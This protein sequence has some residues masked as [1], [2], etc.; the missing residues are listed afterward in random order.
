MP[1]KI[2]SQAQRQTLGKLLR[3]TRR[4][5]GLQQQA[6]AKKLGKPHSFISRYENGERRLD[7]LELK[8][9]CEACGTS[10]PQFVK[11]LEAALKA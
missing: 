7:V 6:L 5:A 2:T 9:V 3:E 10:L 4:A 1:R 8:H 11:K